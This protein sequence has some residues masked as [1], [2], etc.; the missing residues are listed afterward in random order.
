MKRHFDL[1]YRSLVMSILDKYLGKALT[2]RRSTLVEFDARVPYYREYAL[3]NGQ[4]VF[5]HIVVNRGPNELGHGVILGGA[6]GDIIKTLEESDDPIIMAAVAAPTEGLDVIM[7]RR[8]VIVTLPGAVAELSKLF[9][10][11]TDPDELSVDLTPMVVEYHELPPVLAK[12]HPNSVPGN[13]FERY[14][15]GNSSGEE[16]YLIENPESGMRAFGVYSQEQGKWV[17]T[18]V[19]Q[20]PGVE[21][22][23]MAHD[24]WFTI[25]PIMFR[26]DTPLG[27]L[28]ATW[29]KSEL[30]VLIKPNGYVEPATGDDAPVG[31]CPDGNMLTRM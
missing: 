22:D 31:K 14:A 18:E 5:T 9:C 11:Y 16:L 12:Y 6:G 20:T 13:T 8:Y 27:V 15:H 25:G 30:G 19:A 17:V 3:P 7:F 29:K 10:E 24:E 28:T 26:R 23:P 21:V 4:V 1:L 2:C